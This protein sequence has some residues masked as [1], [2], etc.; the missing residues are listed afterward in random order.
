MDVYKNIY[1]RVPSVIARVIYGTNLQRIHE[2][3]NK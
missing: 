1:T 3:N 2:L